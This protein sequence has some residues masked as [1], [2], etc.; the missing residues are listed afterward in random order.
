MTD[1][2]LPPDEGPVTDPAELERVMVLAAKNP[3]LMGPVMR[4]LLGARLC[5][6][7]P[8]H[9]ELAGEHVMDVRDGLTWNTYRDEKGDFA[10]VFTSPRAA[11]DE[12]RASLRDQKEQPAILELPARVL[13]HFLNNG[14]TTARVMAH[15]GATIRLD[16][17]G[18]RAL[19]EGGFTEQ[20]PP[21]P[22]KPGTGEHMIL[23][24][25]HPDNVPTKLRQAIRVFCVQR[26]GAVAV[27]V[28][29]PQDEATGAVDDKD[30]RV[31]LRLRDN[32][33]YFYNDF[34]IMVH[35]NTAKP[36][37][38]LL[39]VPSAAQW[40]EPQMEFLRKAT[41]VWPLVRVR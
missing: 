28:C 2:E 11:E 7:V 20:Q 22:R 32:P 23:V 1:D 24:P 5:V 38:V 13:F 21:P 17:D 29:H 18:I 3:A 40:E 6:F 39:G 10:A 8:P 26:Q 30:L 9:P 16:P 27:Y 15:N 35:K 33:G 37:K 4:M 31:L 36:Y 34:Q 12:K 19:M 14:R 25:V 41:P